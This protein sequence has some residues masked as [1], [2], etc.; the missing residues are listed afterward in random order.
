[1]EKV[2][3]PAE[4]EKHEATWIA[5]PHNKADW[6]NDEI[7]FRGAQ[8]AVAEIVSVLSAHEFVN[9]LCNDLISQ[10]EAKRTLESFCST[11][12]SIE[13]YT[14]QM[15]REW[16][17]DSGPTFV[18][19]GNGKQMPMMVCWLFNGWSKYGNYQKDMNISWFIGGNVK[20]KQEAPC[21]GSMVERVVLEGGAFDVNGHGVLMATEQCLLSDTQVRNPGMT[22]VDYEIMF[23]KYLGIEEIIWLKGGIVG[24]DTNGHIDDVA[25][26]TAKRFIAVGVEE[27][28]DDENYDI[29][30]ENLE[31]LQQW[32]SRKGTNEYWI[33][34]LQFPKPIY[35]NGDRLPASYLNFYIANGV[36]LVPTFNDSADVNVLTT[37]RSLFPNRK[38]VGIHSR[39][40][41]LGL[42]TIHCLTQQQ[43]AL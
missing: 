25:R 10:D 7:K 43:P 18:I 32:Q 41:V 40:L 26:F 16:L 6:E 20:C 8:S 5:W 31:R 12:S 14:V 29:T 19:Q 1:M 33:K 39:D 11:F 30:H 42:G 37:F 9:V 15:N 27:N 21:R 38:V 2:R 23:Q 22:K 34:K 28:R 17:R 36:V 35:Y 13:F 3:M 24:D 4:W